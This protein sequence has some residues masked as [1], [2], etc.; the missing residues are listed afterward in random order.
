[1][2]KTLSAFICIVILILSVTA[3]VPS[4]FAASYSGKCGDALTWGLDTFK[5][6]LTVEGSGKMYD[7]TSSD[8]PEWDRYQNYIK[9]VEIE[10]GAENIGAYAFYNSNGYKYKKMTSLFL[11]DTV[12]EIGEY[13]FRGSPSLKNVGG[14]EGIVLIGDYA[15]RDCAALTDFSFG[16]TT[17]NIGSGAFSLCSSLQNVTLPDSLYKISSAAFEGC[18]ALSDITIPVGVTELGSRVFANCTALKNIVY[19]PQSMNVSGYGC[20]NGAGGSDGMTLTVGDGVT[21]IPS[22]LCAYSSALKSVKLGSDVKNIGSD[23]FRGS[24][25]T[26]F[27]I[28]ASV[29]SV[30]ASAFSGCN[31]LTAFTAAENNTAFS[32]GSNGELMNKAGNTIIRYPGGRAA[33]SYTAGDNITAVGES[34]FRES[35]KLTSVTFTKNL[36]GMGSYAFADCQ[37]LESV[38]LSTGITA[39]PTGAFLDCRSLSS[40]SIGSVKT[41][42]SYAFSGCK[43]FKRLTTGSMLTTIGDYAFSQCDGLTDVTLGAGVKQIGNFAFYYC[44]ELVNVSVPST[45]TTIYSYAFADCVNLMNVSL[46]QGLKTIGNYAFLNCSAL[47]SIK[48]PQSVTTI[49]TYSLGYKYSGNRYTPISGFKIYCYSGSAGY[50]YAAGNSSFSY[51]LVTDSTDPG[52]DIPLPEEQN[53]IQ[54]ILDMI[55]SFDCIGFIR[56]LLDILFPIL[57]K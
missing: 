29:N 8:H 35:T 52:D 24:G 36:I 18:T 14:G 43:S 28:T 40:I 9:T 19:L 54:K 45:V 47:S 53:P 48:I 3:S 26:I 20:F 41:I 31:S 16:E 33:T 4:A 1:M 57:Y 10:S 38:S 5:G 11:A 6:V 15:F 42:G 56:N 34:S 13:A 27:N 49:G 55:F 32:A 30:S 23:A 12:K 37:K 25:I 44:R 7:Y 46:S 22:G 51:E 50:T 21:L 2:K 39:L 17:E